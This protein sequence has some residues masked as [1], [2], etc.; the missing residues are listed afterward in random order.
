MY[1]TALITGASSGL[2]RGLTAWFAAR[3]VKVYGA[4]RR[5]DEVAALAHE[6]KTSIVPVQLD[7][8]DPAATLRRVRELDEECG[9]LDLVIANAGIGRDTYAPKLSW[10]D[11]EEVIQVNVTGAAA[12][13]T[14]AL[15]PMVERDR[16]H[17]V[18][19]SSIA[20]G[21]GL[22]RSAAYSAS[23]AFLS[24]FLEGL[25]VD[26]KPTGV[27]VTTIEPGF[28]RTPLTEKNA[29][30]LP[31]ILEADD[32]VERMG[33]A[34]LRGESTFAFPWQLST[35]MGLARLLPNGVWDAA[36]QKLSPGGKRRS[37]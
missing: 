25:R 15:A 8:A 22:P 26:L 20:A 3:G 29:K 36:G 23:K 4:A 24:T 9:G 7:V 10:R 30:H 32:A 5:V 21:R 14:A 11:I 31:F 1:K 12:T 37:H 35:A 2:G 6:Q 34:I 19:I 33:E 16:G 18:G 13:L 28:V 17:L 27:K